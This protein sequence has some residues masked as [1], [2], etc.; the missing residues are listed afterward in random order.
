MKLLNFLFLYFVIDVYG[1]NQTN[2]ISVLIITDPNQ[3]S[4]PLSVGKVLKILKDDFNGK[5]TFKD[6]YNVIDRE[7]Y[8][9]DDGKPLK[10]LKSGVNF[11]Q[12][13]EGCF[14]KSDGISLI[15]DVSL[16]GYSFLETRFPNVPYFKLRTSMIHSFIESVSLYVEQKYAYDGAFIFQNELG[17]LF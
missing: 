17:E 1:Q 12:F 15:L 13:L 2:Q 5:V 10:N 7:S 11:F 3:D 9:V 8:V 14:L 4:I 16:A 6:Y